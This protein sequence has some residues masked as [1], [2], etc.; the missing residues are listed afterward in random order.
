MNKNCDKKDFLERNVPS[1]K[2]S[3][4][5]FLKIKAPGSTATASLARAP[6]T[7]IVL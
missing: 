7:A 2:P 1:Q 6:Y 4:L 5:R 3:T